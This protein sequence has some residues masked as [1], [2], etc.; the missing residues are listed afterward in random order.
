MLDRPVIGMWL[1]RFLIVCTAV[2]CHALCKVVIHDVAERSKLIVTPGAVHPIVHDD[3]VNIML[4][5]HDLGIHTYLQII[6]AKAGQIFLCQ[7]GLKNLRIY[8]PFI[9]GQSPVNSLRV[10]YALVPFFV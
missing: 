4:R 2:S 9:G 10:L 6:T 1:F 8:N 5:E 3:K 7:S